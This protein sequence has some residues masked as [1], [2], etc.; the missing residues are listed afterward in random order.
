MQQLSST[1]C[2]RC[3]RSIWTLSMPSLPRSVSLGQAP[4]RLLW[5]KGYRVPATSN[6]E[7][8][9]VAG[10]SGALRSGL[11]AVVA[12]SCFRTSR[13]LATSKRSGAWAWAR[14]GARKGVGGSGPPARLRISPCYLSTFGDASLAVRSLELAR[15][16]GSELQSCTAIRKLQGLPA[17]LAARDRH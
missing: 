10:G 4:L 11:R 13:R 6:I 5:K 12:Y 16:A 3:C 15:E 9:S 7:K 1:N 14:P 8:L 2:F 17:P